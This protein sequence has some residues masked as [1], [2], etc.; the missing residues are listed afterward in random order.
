VSTP[1]RP[2]ALSYV[3]LF[4]PPFFW[5]TNFIVG[6][7]LVGKVPPWTL[8]T[9]RFGV[10]ALILLPF[11]LYKAPWRTVPRRLWAPLCLMSLSGVFAFNS[12]LYIGLHYTTAINATLV[13][14]AAPLTTACLAW[15]IIG[16]KMTLRRS[17]GIFLSFV[18]VGWIVS[19]GSVEN[20]YRLSF[21]RG[22]LIVL[23]AT[24]LWGLYSVM[25][26]RMMRDISP[27]LLTGLTTLIGVVFLIPASLVELRHYPAD[28][29]D[30]EVLL[31]F[32]Y[33]GIFPSL[34]SF[35]IWNRSIFIFGPTRTTLV[36]N[37]LP[38]FAVIL[39][40]TI[41]HEA[42]HSY[43]IIG[44]AILIAGVLLG[45]LERPAGAPL[46]SHKASAS[47]DP[48]F[49]ESRPGRDNPST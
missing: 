49:Q 38:L 39:S 7:A 20:L 18:G 34:V 10:S 12:V 31:A 6:K 33:L 17:L 47:P 48:G 11:I 2:S 46:S 23:G 26:K 42:I 19:E 13:N 44:G 22:D 14:S 16:E 8:N 36:Y 21:N 24:A 25:A 32:A 37:S 27:L 40:V 4:L 35:V 41:L 1:P 43:Q 15:M 29:F 28:L 45:T 9:G 5:S 3:L 30:S